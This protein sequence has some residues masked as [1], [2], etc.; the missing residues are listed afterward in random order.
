MLVTG[1]TAGPQTFLQ[2]FVPLVHVH[3]F[4]LTFSLH[5][6]VVAELTLVSFGTLALLEERTQHRLWINTCKEREL[7]RAPRSSSHDALQPQSVTFVDFLSSDYRF[8]QLV[9]LIQLF[10]LIRLFSGLLCLGLSDLIK[11]E[12]IQLG[13]F[14]P[15]QIIPSDSL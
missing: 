6:Q 4:L 3:T 5:G 2:F 13:S 12:M 9:E 7:I 1:F 14:K 11:Q 8:K 15:L 10:L